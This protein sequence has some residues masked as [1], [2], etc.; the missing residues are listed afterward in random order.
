MLLGLPLRMANKIEWET[1]CGCWR[2]K[3]WKS[4]SGYGKVK[5]AGVGRYAHRVTY[6]LLVGEIPRGLVLHHLCYTRECVN[7]FHLVP[8]T[9]QFNVLDGGAVLFGAAK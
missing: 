4:T 9:Q 3:G 1:I 7:P 8:E 5:V 6:E 2:W